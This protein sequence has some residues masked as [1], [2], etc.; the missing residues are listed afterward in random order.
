[1]QRR[2]Q[3]TPQLLALIKMLMGLVGLIL[4]IACSNLANLLLARARARSR[5]IAIR[6]SIGAGRRRVV[7]QLMTESLIVAAMG[8]VA[9]VIFAY[10]GILLLQ[11]LSVPSE[12]PSALGVQLDWRVVQFSLL[13]ALASCIFFGLAP[14]WQTVRMDFVSALKAGGHGVSGARRTFGRDV[15]VSGQIALAMVVLIAAGMFLAGFRKML[16]MT[17]D[18]RTDQLISMD[19]APALVHYSPEQTKVFYRQLVDRVRTMAGV[20]AVA[21][22]ESLPLSPSQTTVAVVRRRAISFRKAARRRSCSEPR[23]TPAYFS[24]MNVRNRTRARLHRCRPQRV[25]PRG[26]CEPAVR[27]DLL[28]GAGSDRKADSAGWSGRL[29]GRSDRRGQDRPLSDR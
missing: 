19:T 27:Q 8:G 21:M 7:R 3:Q 24:T 22:T 20:S 1:M 18:F 2:I 10:G 29:V 6:L 26:D 25:A 28:A 23:L 9:G 16:V 4:I 14:A 15:L 13:A 17:P 5:E 11:T 12:P